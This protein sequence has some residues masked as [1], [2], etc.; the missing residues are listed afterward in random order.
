MIDLPVIPLPR[1]R[2]A[3]S[4]TK[5]D[6][7]F[8]IKDSAAH[9][10]RRS[11]L[12]QSG[13]TFTSMCCLNRRWIQTAASSLWRLSLDPHSISA[14]QQLRDWQ[15]RSEESN[16]F[17]ASHRRDRKPL[18]SNLFLQGLLLDFKRFAL[19]SKTYG[20]YSIFS[21]QLISIFPSPKI[22]FC[23]PS[24]LDSITGYVRDCLC[25]SVSK[26]L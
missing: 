4:Q 9:F 19:R 1:L 20:F 12:P 6:I 17:Q 10:N 8:D 2:Q 14:S 26:P 5:G 11:W 23:T 24:A 3:L 22:S 18:G 7:N 13:E 25:D 15:A 16:W 21:S